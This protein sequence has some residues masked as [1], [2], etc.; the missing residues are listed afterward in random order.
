M[1]SETKKKVSFGF[2][3]IEADQKASRVRGLFSDVSEKYDLMNDVMSFG[4]HRIWKDQFVSLLSPEEHKSYL[5]VAGGTGDIALKIAD[6][7]GSGK[8][9]T[10]ADLTFDMLRCGMSRDVPYNDDIQRINANAEQ[11]PFQDAYFDGYTISY[12]IRNVTSIEKVLS[13]AYRVLKPGGKFMCLEFTLPP[14]SLFKKIYDAYSFHILPKMGHII[15][16]DEASYRYLAESIRRFPKA[17]LFEKYIQD[18][19]FKNTSYKML[20]AGITA[21]HIGYKIT[22]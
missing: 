2:E 20:S 11:L 22:L 5:D 19:G 15:S 16:D 10:I 18:A 3:D 6:Q 17:T 13:E 21:I 7:C 14:Y 9:I 8:N 12:G 1:H 4:F